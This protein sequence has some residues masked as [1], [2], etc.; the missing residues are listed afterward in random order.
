[1]LV[2]TPEHQRVFA[3]AGWTKQRFRE[4][5]EPLLMLDIGGTRVPKFRPGSMMIVRAGGDAGAFSAIIEG[6]IG[7]KM[8]S[9]PITCRI[10][11]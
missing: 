1:M 4:E 5:L 11:R 6:W 2:M 10:S 3:E 7:G 8:G 9:E